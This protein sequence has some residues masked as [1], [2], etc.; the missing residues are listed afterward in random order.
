MLKK[1]KKYVLKYSSKYKKTPAL[2]IG[3]TSTHNDDFYC[4]N[5]LNL[6]RTKNKL[7]SPEKLRFVC[8]WNTF[9]KKYIG[10]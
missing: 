4:L 8:C 5:Y 3:I 6:F 2:F 1:K 10:V 7:E 9:S